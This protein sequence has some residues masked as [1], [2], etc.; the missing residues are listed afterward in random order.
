M[1]V[2]EL[3]PPDVEA[4][5][6]SLAMKLVEAALAIESI[7]KDKRN[8][9]HKYDY[10]SAESILTA[11]RAELLTRHVLVIGS[12]DH[13]EERARETKQGETSI[14]TVHM[15]FTVLDAESGEKLEVPWI[16]RGEDPADKGVGK[17]LT[18]SVKTFLRQLLL[19]P[20]GDDPEADDATDE[21]AYGPANG[22]SSVNLIEHARGLSNAQLNAALVSVGLSALQQPF[23]YFT[24]VPSEFAERVR[25]ALDAERNP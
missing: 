13:T 22:A 16:G 17:A 23:G 18:N 2:V 25:A 3:E 20:Y 24:R 7:A 5:P 6:T 10:A 4:R 9:F 8:S 21:R 11:A 19:L 12:E 1:S 15:I 14:T